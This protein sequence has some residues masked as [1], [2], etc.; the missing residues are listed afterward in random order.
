MTP[1][2]SHIPD[3]IHNRYDHLCF[4]RRW[5][6]GREEWLM[7]GESSAI[8]TA[9]QN[10]PIRPDFLKSL[11]EVSLI[12]GAVATT[13]IEGNTLTE[14]QVQALQSGE[15]KLPESRE[16][17]QT[18]VDNVLSALNAILQEVMEDR[19][20]LITS[21][22][23]RGFH[24]RI[25]KGIGPTFA[26]VPGEFRRTNVTVG[27]YRAPSFS[28]V[29]TLIER[30]C[31]WLRKEFHFETGQTFWEAAIQAIVT[32][33]YIAWIHPFSDGNGRTARLLEFFLLVRSG[34]PDIASHVLSNHYNITRNEYY[35]QID[36]AMRNNDL[37]DFLRYAI[38]GLRDGLREVLGKIQENQRQIT[39]NN[40]I[41]TR[42]DRWIDAENVQRQIAKRRRNLIYHMPSDRWVT[43]DEVLDLH[44][45]IFREYDGGKKSKMLQRDLHA[46]IDDKLLL[47]DKKRYRANIDALRVLMAR[48]ATG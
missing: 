45:S 10:T 40:Y 42:Y 29:P 37:T 43:I 21:R 23:I 17:L 26:A 35:R 22:L 25:G 46:L 13:A 12:K 11:L 3:G 1:D 36:L 32:H 6:L 5:E 33:I 20:V 30:L 14:E 27:P 19:D 16:Y 7:L 18:E 31:S 38:Q 2:E 28:D 4:K 8:I 41:F 34:V 48:S 47:R 15:T 44:S 9:I 24:E 39:W